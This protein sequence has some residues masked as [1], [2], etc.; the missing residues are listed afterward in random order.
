MGGNLPK[1]NTGE[2]WLDVITR[3]GEETGEINLYDKLG[4]GGYAVG[5]CQV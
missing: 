4:E 2:G 5:K 1:K 3:A